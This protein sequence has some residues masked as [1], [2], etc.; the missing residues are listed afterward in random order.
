MDESSAALSLNTANAAD[1]QSSDRVSMP[2]HPLTRQLLQAG[3]GGGQAGGG[4]GGQGAALARPAV[5]DISYSA[6]FTLPG[7]H[8]KTHT[9]TKEASVTGLAGAWVIPEVAPP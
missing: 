3:G 6:S 4:G 9:F 2:P 8:F 5:G 7:W 1:A